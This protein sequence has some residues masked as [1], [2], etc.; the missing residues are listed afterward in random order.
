[1][2]GDHHCP[3][4]HD[5][6]NRDLRTWSLLAASVESARQLTAVF[7]APHILNSARRFGRVVMVRNE[8]RWGRSWSAGRID[9]FH[10]HLG[11]EHPRGLGGVVRHSRRYGG[12]ASTGGLR[13]PRVFRM[14]RPA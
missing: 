2:A 14:S 4:G 3:L 12:T 6:R 5:R 11:R 13:A 1:V 10:P 9:E 7:P 8:R